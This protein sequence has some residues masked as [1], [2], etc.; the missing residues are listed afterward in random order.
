MTTALV[1]CA[2]VGLQQFLPQPKNPVNNLVQ[3]TDPQCPD[4]PFRIISVADGYVQGFANLT[5]HIE[6]IKSTHLDGLLYNEVF[7]NIQPPAAAGTDYDFY[8]YF[9]NT[10]Y[11]SSDIRIG[12]LTHGKFSPIGYTKVDP[13]TA[14]RI[15]D[16]INRQSTLKLKITALGSNPETALSQRSSPT[17]R[18]EMAD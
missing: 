18:I 13:K 2:S 1:A 8:K 4:R 15:T 7:F 10:R 16:S 9:F 17:C 6:I 12:I 11:S 5:G 3:T 14:D